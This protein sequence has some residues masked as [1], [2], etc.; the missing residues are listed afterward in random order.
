MKTARIVTNLREAAT[1]MAS[2]EQYL[3]DWSSGAPLDAE[4]KDGVAHCR[5][6]LAS[7]SSL[8]HGIATGL[9]ALSSD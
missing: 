9:E 7:L 5:S 1:A 8:V 3:E 6:R 2:A 4:R